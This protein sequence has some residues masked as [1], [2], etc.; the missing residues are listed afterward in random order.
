[1]P[2]ELTR[3]AFGCYCAMVVADHRG[4]K[5]QNFLSSR[6]G[7]IWFTSVRDAIAFTL[8]P[9]EPKNIA[10][11]YVNDMGR[12]SWE[13]PEP[14]TWVGAHGAWC[15]VGSDRTG[16][17]GV[18]E[19]VPSADKPAAEA[20]TSTHGS[21]VVAF[22]GVPPNAILSAPAIPAGES[23]KTKVLVHRHSVP[24]TRR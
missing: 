4:P 22:A 13:E 6:D 12:A 1:M 8:L 3:D 5:G 10:G 17:M 19:P 15:M 11:F 2:H 9:E 14:G 18:P 24:P 20:F 7:P 23:T 21:A 16:A